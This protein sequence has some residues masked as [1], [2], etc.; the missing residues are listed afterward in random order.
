MA[1][2][3]I[4]IP[5][6]PE[7]FP[8]I[9]RCDTGTSRNQMTHTYIIEGMTCEGCVAKVKSQL[10]MN[11]DVTAVDLQLDEKKAVIS[12]QRHLT[13][14]DLQESIGKDSKYRIQAGDHQ[15]HQVTMDEDSRSWF[16]TYKPILLIFAFITVVGLIAS[17][18]NGRVNTMQFMS[19]FMGGFF[20][21][22]SFFKLLDLDGFADSY[23][24]Y[25]I[26]AKR[27][28]VW[29]YMYAFIELGLGLAYITHFN[30][31]LT[32]IITLI[33][34]SVSLVGV[35]QSVLNKSKI[36]CACLGAVFNL[37]MSTVTIVEDGLMIVMSGIMI[38]GIQ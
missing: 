20:L 9:L 1:S 3:L 29:G 12:M 17:T 10:L 19:A 6:L 14:S 4:S 38:T 25:D 7:L 21:V 5:V 13:V 33:V 18:D 11:P 30:P 35:L 37:P 24:M 26:V 28:K 34:M 36:R 8:I 16:A 15:S 32:N 22:F 27:V 23:A 2:L 31:F